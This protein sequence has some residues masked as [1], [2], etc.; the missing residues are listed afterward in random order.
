MALLIFMGRKSIYLKRKKFYCQWNNKIKNFNR[1]IPYFH[2]SALPHKNYMSSAKSQAKRAGEKK[3]LK[4][5]RYKTARGEN[6]GEKG[7]LF[8][9]VS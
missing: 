7:K 4:M 2:A 8:I 5:Q 1:K 6:V 3:R 9:R